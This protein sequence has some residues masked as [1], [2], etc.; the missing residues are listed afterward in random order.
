MVFGSNMARDTESFSGWLVDYALI[1][2]LLKHPQR[3]SKQ[4]SAAGLKW[5]SRSLGRKTSL[6]AGL[7]SYTHEE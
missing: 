5:Q 6:K 4:L 3:N 7:T 2:D 1:A